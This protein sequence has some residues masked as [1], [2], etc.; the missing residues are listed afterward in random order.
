MTTNVI[1]GPR[2]ADMTYG[3]WSIQIKTTL[4]FQDAWDVVKGY[5][6]PQEKEN[7]ITARTTALAKLKKKNKKTLSFIYQGL[8]AGTF[9]KVSPQHLKKHGTS[10]KKY[11]MEMT[12]QKAFISNP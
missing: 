3:H 10:L 4:E 7:F 2:L 6:E 8:D 12:K 5:E 11:T 9:E 1:D